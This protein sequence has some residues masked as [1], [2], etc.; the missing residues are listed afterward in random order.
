MNIENIQ[1]RIKQLTTLA[2]EMRMGAQFLDGQAYYREMAEAR[3][4]ENE[5]A[6]LSAQLHESREGT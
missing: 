5:A 6:T 1:E 3:R 4:L 2:H